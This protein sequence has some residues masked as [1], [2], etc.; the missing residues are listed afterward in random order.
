MSRLYAVI[1]DLRFSVRLATRS[2][3]LTCAVVATLALGVGLD[4]G[5]LSI[6]DGSVRR[7]R[8]QHDPDSFVHVQVDFESRTRRSRA[9]LFS[10]TAADYLVY[11]ESVESLSDLAAWH[12]VRAAVADDAGPTLAMLVSCNFFNVYGLRHAF[13]GRAFTPADCSGTERLAVI[14]EEVWRSRFAADPQI[15]GK[16]IEINGEPIAVIGVLPAN[17]AGQLRGPGYWMPLHMQP[18]FFRNVDL[19]RDAHTPWLALEGRLRAGFSRAAARHELDML[20]VQQDRQHADRKT[21]ISLTNG[22]VLED[23][24]LGRTAALV[25][26]LTMSGL[27]LV[28]AIA[29][30]NVTVLLLSRAAAR[31]REI[32]IRV[33]LGASRS[34]LVVMLLTEGVSLAVMALPLS[35]YL[36]YEVP[37]IAKAMVPMLPYY[38]MRPNLAVFGYMVL[39][40]AA[41][42]CLAGLAPATESLRL[43]IWRG[44]H[45]RDTFQLL[46]THWRMRDVLIASQV[47]MSLVLLIGAGVF[48][49]AQSAIRHHDP[50]LDTEHTLAMPL[51]VA[52]ATLPVLM[53]RVRGL[54]GV[55]SVAVAQASPFDGELMPTT[56]VRRADQSEAPARQTVSVNAVSPEYFRT[57]KLPVLHGR[58]FAR[59]PA[60]TEVVISQSLARALWASEDPIGR[61]LLDESGRVQSVIGVARDVDVLS[62][63]P[64]TMY[65]PR[66]DG[67]P[68]GVLLVN[69]EGST[70]AV[71]ERM[72]EL[73]MELAPSAVV[74]PVTLATAFEDLA[75]RFAVLVR[76]VGFLGVVGIVL[77]VIGIYG[78]VA[79]AVSGR[80]KEVGIRMALGASKPVVMR[81][82]L[83]SGIA[84]VAAGLTV[85]LLVAVAAA[86]VLRS[87]LSG[88]PVPIDVRD[89]M[90]FGSVTTVLIA[91]VL[92]AMSL[93][94]WRATAS[95]PMDALRQE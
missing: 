67:E 1:Q 85:G 12:A 89:P 7:P 52:A 4:A 53:D 84:P 78:V 95:N 3:F 68:G 39:L 70:S 32:A 90:I 29:C 58:A 10:T 26:L 13:I 27:T 83:S 56:T 42:G 9:E 16:S 11:R 77:A 24:L 45:G 54:P 33:S 21:T 31:Q 74:Q 57:V 66:S 17:F 22:S 88:T 48:V 46:G 59:P 76:F 18:M 28:L 41:V 80:T 36:A 82:L 35:A 43:N 61:D 14:S 93:P 69:V 51:R 44:T 40:T 92:A 94:A 81:M 2:P 75:N 72:R 20:A 30:A 91:T 87:V 71:A 47:A 63:S 62:A 55:Y 23:P 65:R 19:T 15:A 86:E 25:M 38:N 64:P 49:R 73:L 79:F 8:V 50:G 34:R 60:P 6:V 37:R 5:V